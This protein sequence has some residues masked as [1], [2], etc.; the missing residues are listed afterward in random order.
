M[1]DAPDV[2]GPDRSEAIQ[3]EGARV[4]LAIWALVGEL[5]DFKARFGDP[6][7]TQRVAIWVDLRAQRKVVAEALVNTLFAGELDVL[8]V[9]GRRYRR[10]GLQWVLRE[11]RR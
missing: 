6:E 4:F 9:A 2:L 3:N 1:N 8:D 10:N 7:L 11:V 5:H